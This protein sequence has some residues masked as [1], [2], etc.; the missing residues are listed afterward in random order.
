MVKRAN[1]C[2]LENL[3]V[4]EKLWKASKR[5]DLQEIDENNHSKI[6]FYI[7]KKK[8]KLAFHLEINTFYMKT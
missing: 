5:K 6:H 1:D 3:S 7:T 8:K 2:Q 4:N